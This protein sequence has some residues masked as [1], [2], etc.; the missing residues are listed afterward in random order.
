MVQVVLSDVHGNTKKNGNTA[1]AARNCDK[2]NFPLRQQRRIKRKSQGTVLIVPALPR[3]SP[4]PNRCIP[5]FS[6]GKLGLYHKEKEQQ[7]GRKRI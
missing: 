6:S 5:V 3:G 1:K 7:H 4:A 2:I